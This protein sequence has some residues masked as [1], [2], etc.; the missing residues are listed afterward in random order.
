MTDGRIGGSSG[1][2]MMLVK[3]VGEVTG[4][5]VDG[6]RAG[7]TNMDVGRPGNDGVSSMEVIGV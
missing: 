6:C 7:G 5:F 1:R 2:M 3:M 4:A